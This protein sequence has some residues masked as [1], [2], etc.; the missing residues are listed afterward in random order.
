[1]ML[2]KQYWSCYPYSIKLYTSKVFHSAFVK[3]REL[4]V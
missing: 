3:H 4:D 1:M 2:D